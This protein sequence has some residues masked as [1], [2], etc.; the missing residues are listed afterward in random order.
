MARHEP[1]HPVHETV[2]EMEWNRETGRLEVAMRLDVLDEQWLAKRFAKSRP[3]K[4]WASEYVR[5]RIRIRPLPTN[6]KRREV[7]DSCT[8]HWIGRTEEGSHA[9]W[10][11]EI[12]P[13]DGEAPTWIDHRVLFE[14]RENYTN[15]VLILGKVPR[16][17]LSLTSEKPKAKLDPIP[18]E[19]KSSPDG[20]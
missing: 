20:R 7:D 2:S 6:E 1:L 18:D 5:Q 17:S 13:A 14:R 9:W 3:T 8:Y 4:T 19:P 16:Q 15:R 12:E 10:Y 11:F